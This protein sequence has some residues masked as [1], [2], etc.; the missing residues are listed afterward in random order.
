MLRQLKDEMSSEIVTSI[1]IRQE[2]EKRLSNTI[3][4]SLVKK[5]DS[6]KNHN[7]EEQFRMLN[8]KLILLEDS[9]KENKK[10]KKEQQNEIIL[11]VQE[12]LIQIKNDFVE[13]SEKICSMS[14]KIEELENHMNSCF[15]SI[16]TKVALIG[17]AVTEL[18]ISAAFTELA[19]RI[20]VVSVM[21]Q[22]IE[23]KMERNHRC[24]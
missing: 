17:T 22:S 2:M 18:R 19:S 16:L 11:K 6:L 20:S 1:E 5:I 12:D 4:I 3:F 7:Y 10:N 9:L 15:D 14:E 8:K 21:M 24:S 23:E 13:L